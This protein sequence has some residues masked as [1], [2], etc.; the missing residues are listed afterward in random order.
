MKIP[1]FLTLLPVAG[2]Q[3]MLYFHKT[4]KIKEIANSSLLNLWIMQRILQQN[5][6]A[7]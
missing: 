5:E 7:G 4:R 2:Q 6:F 3:L 1:L